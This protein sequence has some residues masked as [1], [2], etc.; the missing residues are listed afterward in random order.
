MAV[1]A[2]AVTM[3]RP[4]R[5]GDEVR[6]GW[7]TI[8]QAALEDEAVQKLVLDCATGRLP[9][10]IV[11]AGELLLPQEDVNSLC[12]AFRLHWGMSFFLS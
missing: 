10:A 1:K 5:L 3:V 7:C 11:A 8:S 9:V 6:S 4:P 2:Q 12:A